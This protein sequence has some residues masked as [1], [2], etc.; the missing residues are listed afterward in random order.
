MG[1]P[2]ALVEFTFLLGDQE[3]GIWIARDITIGNLSTNGFE[4]LRI[5]CGF[6]ASGKQVIRRIGNERR[7][8]KIL[9]ENQK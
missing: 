8:R 4:D 3:K 5:A 1:E 6:K 2:G 9:G 7:S